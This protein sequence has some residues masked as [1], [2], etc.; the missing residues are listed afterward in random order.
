MVNET[1]SDL[2]MCSSFSCPSGTVCRNNQCD[3]E[4]CEPPRYIGI[5]NG[6]IF[7]N[8]NNIG[9]KILIVCND[10]YEV[11]G[12]E[13]S[14]CQADGTWSS[15]PT[16]LKVCS[17]PSNLQIHGSAYPSFVE[18]FIYSP[19]GTMNNI[20]TIDA[21]TKFTQGSVVV[22]DCAGGLYLQGY[23]TLYCH[24]TG[25]WIYMPDCEGLGLGIDCI[26]DEVC[27]IQP[28]SNECVNRICRCPLGTS[29]SYSEMRCIEK[30]PGGYADTFN[31]VKEVGQWG[32]SSYNINNYGASVESCIMYCLDRTTY[33][34]RSFDYNYGSNK[35]YLQEVTYYDDPASVYTWN[36]GA[37]F[38]RDCL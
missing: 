19:N 8:M 29:Y 11:V 7:G 14:I 16:C 3:I 6:E 37:Y 21:N 1:R 32:P 35:C 2:G 20:T 4:R 18:A 34:C 10:G 9:S 36:G 24:S 22:F 33:V 5:A 31:E 13:Q 38:L 23:Q 26:V 12:N 30:C 17:A 28:H 15:L 27:S 25:N